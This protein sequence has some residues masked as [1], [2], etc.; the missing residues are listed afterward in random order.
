MFQSFKQMPLHARRLPRAVC[1]ATFALACLGLI[2]AG[3]AVPVDAFAKDASTTPSMKSFHAPL[4]CESCHK[5]N[6]PSAS[7][8]SEACLA[9]HGDK[10]KLVEA[11]KNLPMNPHVSPHWGTDAD[12]S[13]C[14]KEHGESRNVCSYCHTKLDKAMP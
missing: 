6:S 2:A 9:C 12:C 4:A 3:S 11:T 8:A 10:E 14:H 13:F 5:S 7:P 1:T